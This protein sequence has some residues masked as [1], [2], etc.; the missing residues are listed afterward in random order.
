MKKGKIALAA[1]SAILLMYALA[2]ANMPGVNYLK[3]K[4]VN[5]LIQQ[6]LPL[7]SSKAAVAAF[8]QSE[9]IESSFEVNRDKSA[10][11]YAIIRETGWGLPITV[12]TT[13]QFFFTDRDKLDKISIAD[14]GTGP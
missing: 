9:A 3:S 5:Y 13:Y 7:G 8:L 14:I 4:Q 10:V 11:G 12:D 6:R 1:A 2:S